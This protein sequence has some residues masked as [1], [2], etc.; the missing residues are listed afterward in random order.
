MATLFEFLEYVACMAFKFTSDIIP[1]LSSLNS[2]DANMM[3]KEI[4]GFMELY[5]TV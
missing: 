5:S 1:S 3:I 2:V 4:N